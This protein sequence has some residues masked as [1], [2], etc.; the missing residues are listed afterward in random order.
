[1][2]TPRQRGRWISYGSG[3]GG[4]DHLSPEVRAEVEG[5][6]ALREQRQGRVLCV[7]QV[8]VFEHD[9]VPSVAFPPGAALD[10]DSDS[11]DIASAVAQAREALTTWR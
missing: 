1:M 7:V 6:E 5:R 9:A 2:E 10:A 4:K 3:P 11:G 8:T